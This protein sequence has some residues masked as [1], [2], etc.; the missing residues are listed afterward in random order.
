[1]HLEHLLRSSDLTAEDVRGLLQ[2]A[3]S[4][5]ERRDP[6][7]FPDY[8]LALMFEKPSLRTRVSFE[9]A[10][11]QLGGH[12]VYLSPDDVGLG[13][14]ESTQDVAQVLGRYVHAIAARTFAQETVEQLAAH[15]GIPVINA[16]SDEDHPCQGL[17]D[18]LTLWERY[19][20][21]NDLTLAYVGDGNNCA[22][23]LLALT[24]TMGIHFRIASPPGYQLD[25]ARVAEA[26]AAAERSGA[27]ILETTEPEEAVR[28]ADAIY[29]DVWTSMGQEEEQEVRRQVFGP[30]QINEALF[31]AAKP[32]AMLLHPLPAHHGEEVAEGV[33]YRPHSAVFDQAENR[34]HVQK[35]ILATLLGGRDSAPSR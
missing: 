9:M 18:L 21:F 24:A 19:G 32:T 2:R 25:P 3:S 12:S 26:R 4:F 10:M 5:K 35:A 31:K 29:T 23:S 1:M 34:L 28:N 27:T 13:K 30:Y 6:T 16:L 20:R 8:G 33:L 15:S 22:N 11:V 7:R 14:R 17:A